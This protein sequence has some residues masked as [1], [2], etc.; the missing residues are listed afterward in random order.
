MSM[1]ERQ[2]TTWIIRIGVAAL[3]VAVIAS[4]GFLLTFSSDSSPHSYS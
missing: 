2:V 1:S 3:A 4:S